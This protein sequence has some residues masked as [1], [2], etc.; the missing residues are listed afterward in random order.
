MTVLGEI[1]PEELS[2]TPLGNVERMLY[3]KRSEKIPRTL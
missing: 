1:K 2:R 3:G